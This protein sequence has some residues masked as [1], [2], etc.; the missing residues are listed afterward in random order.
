MAMDDLFGSPADIDRLHARPCEQCEQPCMHVFSEKHERPPQPKWLICYL[1][2]KCI[3]GAA[4]D[5]RYTN[6]DIRTA[7][8]T[9]YVHPECLECLECGIVGTEYDG[10]FQLRDVSL[11]E[12]SLTPVGVIHMP[13]EPCAI[14]GKVGKKGQKR[15]FT[16]CNDPDVPHAECN[17][18]ESC[19]SKRR[20]EE[21]TARKTGRTI[22]PIAV[23][24]RAQTEK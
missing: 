8:H 17:V 1:C 12:W 6:N 10:R 16:M 20:R 18:H 14:C 3:H 7:T 4:C 9:L 22:P 19:W 11:K 5:I 21:C 2:K 24:W 15:T 13:C 23:P